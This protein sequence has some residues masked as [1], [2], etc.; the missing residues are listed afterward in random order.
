MNKSTYGLIL[1]VALTMIAPALAAAESEGNER[2]EN[3]DNEK[4]YGEREDHE[5][6][7]RESENEEHEGN[8]MGSGASDIIL[9]VTLA[10]ITSIG[11][12]SAL[13]VYQ[14]KKK[15]TKKLA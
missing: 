8:M 7:Q 10:A 1:L 12:Y 3:E 6:N 9:Y 14:A 2:E 5:N 11:G 4:E 15:A 13:R